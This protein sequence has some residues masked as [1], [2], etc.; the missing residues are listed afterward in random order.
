MS[1]PTAYDD[2]G[3]SDEVKTML[4]STQTRLYDIYR[5]Y[6]ES[7][8]QMFQTWKQ[9]GALPPDEP[10]SRARVHDFRMSNPNT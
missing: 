1:L 10:V 3:K 2:S 7:L 9:E 5:P 8:W 4:C 6:T